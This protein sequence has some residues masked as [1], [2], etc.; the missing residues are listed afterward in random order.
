MVRIDI[1]EAK[2]YQPFVDAPFSGDP[3][4][5][6]IEED[7]DGWEVVRYFTKHNK[8]DTEGKLGSQYVYVLSNEYMPGLLKIG[9]TYN[10]PG[11][12]AGQLFKTG[13]PDSFK[14]EYYGKCFNGMRVER[15]VHKKL[16]DKRVRDDREFFKTEVEEV[17][18]LIDEMI[19]K[20]G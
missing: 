16:K 17:K 2:N 20:F 9:Y 18:I 15:E 13:V 3:E 19:K 14:I 10:D 5:Y 8:I 11:V 6:T 4:F 7:K 12:R 1:E